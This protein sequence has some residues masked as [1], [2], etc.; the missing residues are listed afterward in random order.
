MF[1]FRF[2]VKKHQRRKF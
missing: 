1:N 2:S